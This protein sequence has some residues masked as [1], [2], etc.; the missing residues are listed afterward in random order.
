MVVLDALRGL[1]LFGILVINMRLFSGWIY[2]PES[3]R[4]G[5]TSPLGEAVWFAED[6]FALHKFYSLFSLLFGIGFAIQL[7]R[8]EQREVAFAPIYFRRMLVLFLFGVAHLLVLY[9]WDILH[10]YALCGL[11]LLAL[12]RLDRSAL[13]LGALLI[14]VPPVIGRVLIVESGGALDPQVAF[15][16][17]G[18]RV[19]SASGYDV[20]RASWHVSAEGSWADLVHR[21]LANWVYRTGDILER[22]FF[23]QVL[24]TF[25][26]GLWAGR[27]LM[28]G[29]LLDEPRFLG[30][31]LCWGLAI[32][33]PLNLLLAS[34]ID[35]G[36]RPYTS[37]Q[38]RLE[39]L[40]AF[41]VAP[42]ACA[43]AA[44]FALLWRFGPMRR[45]LGVLVPSGRA[46][47]TN[48]VGQSLLAILLFYGVGFGLAGTLGPAG[49]T[50]AAAGVFAVQAALSALWLRVFR[51]G[52]LESVW[53]RLTY[54]R[55]L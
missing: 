4:V 5:L 18:E 20:G 30:R 23:F 47:L 17:W 2:M 7:T 13:V 29:R 38:I 54:L 51:Y 9:P 6:W 34:M 43:Y 1:A 55:R 22:G 45:L 44:G 24:G 35:G 46:A 39:I 3:L 25:L 53:R 27:R 14:V 21:N 33:L 41:G 12:R 52:P 28:E 11:V 31:I 36:V 15:A 32:G 42:L 10:L 40:R 49:W 50:L 8:A 26:L 37:D 48:Y 16:A 19:M